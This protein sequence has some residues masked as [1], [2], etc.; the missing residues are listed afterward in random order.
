MFFDKWIN[1]PDSVENY[2]D[3]KQ[4][5]EVR[6]WIATMMLMVLPFVNL[7]ILFRWAFADK[8][9]TP[10]NKVNWARGTLIVIFY[11]MVALLFMALIFY[12]FWR[13]HEPQS[14]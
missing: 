9:T 7:F 11:A 8:S 3:D 6:E 12:L 13:L 5:V 2:C 14:M 10:A 4:V 1:A